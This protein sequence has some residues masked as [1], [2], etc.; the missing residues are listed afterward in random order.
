MV[1]PWHQ[2]AE[3]GGHD[4][5][6]R[7]EVPHA[8]PPSDLLD[9]LVD[10]G[11][12]RRASQDIVSPFELVADV[13]VVFILDEGGFV[14]SLGGPFASDLIM[15]RARSVEPSNFVDTTADWGED[16]RN[17][18]EFTRELIPLPDGSGHT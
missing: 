16:I 4:A 10:E 9:R 15:S 1:A 12:P 14:V 17:R 3:V 7:A 8:V 6:V 11:L 5:P 2:V 18:L 13:G